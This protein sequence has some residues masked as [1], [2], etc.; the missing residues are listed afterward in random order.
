VPTA[1]PVLMSYL[2][3]AD[4]PVLS[5]PGVWCSVSH[6]ADSQ[7]QDCVATPPWR[8]CARRRTPRACPGRRASGQTPWQTPVGMAGIK[9]NRVGTQEWT[10][11]TSEDGLHPS[12]PPRSCRSN[13]QAAATQGAACLAAQE[14]HGGAVDPGVVGCTGHGS[15]VVL[16][17]LLGCSR[18]N[19]RATSAGCARCMAV[20]S[21]RL[22]A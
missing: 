19:G 2:Q 9:G 8:C 12:I 6:I 11:K 20:A 22:E 7:H 10:S 15:Q 21:C 17:L 4:A 5:T 13:Q 1:G 16:A 14:R 18:G 3:N